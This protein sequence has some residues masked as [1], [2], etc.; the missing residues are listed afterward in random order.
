[1]FQK[2][3]LFAVTSER[4]TELL[5]NFGLLQSKYRLCTF[6][7]THLKNRIWESK[8]QTRAETQMAKENTDWTS[9]ILKTFEGP[10]S[11][12]RDQQCPW[13]ARM[14]VWSLARYSGLRI[15]SCRYSIGHN[16]GSDLT[17][18]SGVPYAKG[19]PPSQ[20]RLKNKFVVLMGKTNVQLP[21]GKGG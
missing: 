14:Q 1:M 19:Q 5:I 6:V 20:K 9:S 10:T 16:C 12:F 18:G 17:P 4:N 8:S 11:A 7:R 15:L 13:N 2:W 21:N 3:G